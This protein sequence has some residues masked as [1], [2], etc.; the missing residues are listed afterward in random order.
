MTS[1]LT[2]WAPRAA[3]VDLL[4]PEDDRRVAMIE[5]ADG[6]WSA[7][8]LPDGTVYAF[9]LDGGPALPDPRSPWQPFGVHGP[10]RTF[11]AGRI[12]WPSGWA[13][14]DARGA[15]HYELH[16][17]TFTPGG[18]LDSAIE[19]LDH[20]VNLGVEMVELMPLAPFDGD[21]GWGYDGSACTRSTTS[22][23]ARRRCS[24][25]SPR[26]TSAVWPCASTSSTTIS[27]PP[28]TT[29]ASSARTSAT[30]T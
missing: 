27:D 17:G 26:R 18:T 10:S 7:P 29:S 22:T 2:V 14:R 13:G 21:H 12:T 1:E 4:L 9:S 20:L 24:A 5:G 3:A 16:V 25:S 11:D 23:A 6:W 19:R 30:V 8:G 15:V 28:G